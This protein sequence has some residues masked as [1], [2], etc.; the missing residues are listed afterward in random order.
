MH[1]MTN[2]GA[3]QFKS[4]NKQ[5][6]TNQ[7]YSIS[8]WIFLY[9]MNKYRESEQVRLRCGT[10]QVEKVTAYLSDNT[11]KRGSEK[12]L[13]TWGPVTVS[14]V[15]FDIINPLEPTQKQCHRTSPTATACFIFSS[16]AS[17]HT[18][19][20]IS[21]SRISKQNSI[22]FWAVNKTKQLW[23]E[24]PSTFHSSIRNVQIVCLGFCE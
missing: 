18:F 4:V 7:V 9:K 16:L 8:D 10:H 12:L 11:R 20:F 24:S 19:P 21:S 23:D 3:Y 13:E 1:C 22:K 15:L 5:M 14:G 17:R 2:L 6:H